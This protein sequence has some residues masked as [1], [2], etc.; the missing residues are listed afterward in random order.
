MGL[1]REV[2]P[3]S[4]TF[5]LTAP[6]VE[7]LEAVAEG[8][9]SSRQGF[10][11]VQRLDLGCLR[12]R[13]QARG[14]GLRGAAHRRKGTQQQDRRQDHRRN[15][16]FPVRRRRLRLRHGSLRRQGCR[17]TAGRRLLRSRF[18]AGPEHPRNLDVPRRP[19]GPGAFRHSAVQPHPV[20]RPAGPP[21]ETP[22]QDRRG[23]RLRAVGADAAAVRVRPR[24]R[25]HGRPPYCAIAPTGCGS[26]AC[27]R[28]R[29]RESFERISRPTRVNRCLLPQAEEDG[30]AA[31]RNFGTPFLTMWSSG[32]SP[33]R[34][35]IRQPA[36]SP[37]TEV[38]N[39]L[40]RVSELT[41]AVLVAPLVAD[42]ALRRRRPEIWTPLQSQLFLDFAPQLR[43]HLPGP[44]RAAALGRQPVG[45]TVAAPTR[46]AG[47]ADRRTVAAELL[48]RRSPL[49]FRTWQ[50]S[51]SV[52]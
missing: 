28:K 3:G 10:A 46:A 23:D 43:G 36:F 25:G 33:N 27:E 7:R 30:E 39:R 37:A 35:G 32:L 22:Q 41:G 47:Q 51:Q 29:S 8:N 6:G 49:F 34:T 4:G 2:L 21:P 31:L 50:R 12:P 9:P 40:R 19:D 5:V 48:P 15:Q 18:R 45:L 13:H 52:R 1:L 38:A 14:C 16:A 44:C 26:G 17:R 42:P 20:D 11:V 24:N